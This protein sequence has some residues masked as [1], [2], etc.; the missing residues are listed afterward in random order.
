[1]TTPALYPFLTGGGEA[2]GIIASFDWAATPLGS[3]RELAGEP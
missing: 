3:D 2:A 1:M